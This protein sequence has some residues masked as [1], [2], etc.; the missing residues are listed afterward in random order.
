MLKSLR[1]SQATAWR[2]LE[3]LLSTDGGSG[4]T[5]LAQQHDHDVNSMHSASNDREVGS[6]ADED[7]IVVNTSRDILQT[8]HVDMNACQMH[9][10]R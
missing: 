6:L 7:V 3:E 4:C 5:S 8:L 1:F 2:A 10:G 9:N